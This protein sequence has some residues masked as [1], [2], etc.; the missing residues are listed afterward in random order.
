[1]IWWLMLLSDMDLE[2]RRFLERVTF[3]FC[4][5]FLVILGTTLTVLA[6]V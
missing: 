3:I 1:M 2:D 4:V 5:A 6:L